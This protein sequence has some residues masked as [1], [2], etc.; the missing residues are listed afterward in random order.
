MIKRSSQGMQ[1]KR[2]TYLQTVRFTAKDQTCC[3]ILSTYIYIFIYIYVE[4]ERERSF[5]FTKDTSVLRSAELCFFFGIEFHGPNPGH[6]GSQPGFDFRIQSRFAHVVLLTERLR[7]NRRSRLQYSFLQG[8]DLN[9]KLLKSKSV[10]KLRK[11]EAGIL[12]LEACL[13]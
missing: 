12:T 10:V 3:S 1:A 7:R 2:Q 8:E 5:S 9:F 6:A 13:S 11:R 4:R